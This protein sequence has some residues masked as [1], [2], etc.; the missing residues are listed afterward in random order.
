MWNLPKG[1]KVAAAS[2]LKKAGEECGRQKLFWK[3]NRSWGLRGGRGG[4]GG[5]GQGIFPYLAV[6]KKPN[7]T[8]RPESFTHGL[9]TV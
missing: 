6:F 8:K 1:S 7:S 5:E 4:G 9:F 3:K 2:G